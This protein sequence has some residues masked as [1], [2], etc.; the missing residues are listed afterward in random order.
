MVID[1]FFDAFWR[2]TQDGQQDIVVGR[3]KSATECLA[4]KVFVLL[5]PRNFAD[6]WNSS[7]ES[8]RKFDDGVEWRYC[9]ATHLWGT[10]WAEYVL[11]VMA[12]NSVRFCNPSGSCYVRRRTREYELDDRETSSLRSTFESLRRLSTL[13]P[14]SFT[15]FV[16]IRQGGDC[17]WT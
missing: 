16:S 8:C 4:R 10:L 1:F 5:F 15:V 6:Y 17:L 2:Q 7:E 14:L 11:M 3:E 9:I 13:D 12:V